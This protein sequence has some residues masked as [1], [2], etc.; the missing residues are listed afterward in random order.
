[1]KGERFEKKKAQKQS[2]PT[3]RSQMQ[4]ENHNKKVQGGRGVFCKFVRERRKPDLPDGGPY[5]K[6]SHGAIVGWG[7]GGGG[8]GFRKTSCTRVFN[9][10]NKGPRDDFP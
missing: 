6:R 9:I 3:K 5:L 4:S 1:M 8:G 7:G 2:K 10:G